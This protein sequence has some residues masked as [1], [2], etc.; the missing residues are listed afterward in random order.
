MSQSNSL[1]PV[2]ALTL[3]L[4]RDYEGLVAFG[5]RLGSA[6][7]GFE[8]GLTFVRMMQGAVLVELRALHGADKGGRPK[9]SK[10]VGGFEPW[11]EFVKREFGFSDE[12]A[13]ARMDLWKAG[14]G[15]LKDLAEDAQRG[16]SVIFD[17]PIS[18][19]SESEF[20]QLKQVTHKLTDG[21]TVAL[22]QQELGLYKGEHGSALLGNVVPRKYQPTKKDGSP[23]A[24]KRTA[25][26][27]EAATTEAACAEWF[28]WNF[29]VF[30]A[31]HLEPRATW[32]GLDDVPLANL[33]D[34]LKRLTAEVDEV[35]R[36]RGIQPAKL[37][38][39]ATATE[40]ATTTV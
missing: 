30:R 3:N 11:P 1:A 29:E 39:W 38:D 21:K 22:I 5:H 37:A 24:K 10:Q 9:T 34:V 15:R 33:A 14:K 12:T 20:A 26:E 40:A 23:R 13:R 6:E 31:A 28:G 4:P 36:A 2:E 17:R 32:H 19:L 8:C 7:V 27:I 35:C 18:T 25:A 16:L